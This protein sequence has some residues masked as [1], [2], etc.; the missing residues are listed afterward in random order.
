[1]SAEEK[2]LNRGKKNND[3]RYWI[4]GLRIVVDFGAS[5]A[6]PVVV[7]SMAGKRLDARFG[8]HPWL[9]IAG[10]VLAAML[11]AAL[12]Y[13]SAKRYGRQYQDLDINR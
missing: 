2:P 6:L 1:M 7:L 4:F 9:L 12:I 10:F 5:I 11:S 13:R 3:A 8:T